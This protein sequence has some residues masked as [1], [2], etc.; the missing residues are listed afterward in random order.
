MG[1]RTSRDSAENLVP[2]GV[3]SPDRPAGNESL[4]RP[5]KQIILSYLLIYV[6]TFQFRLQQD[7]KHALNIKITY[8]SDYFL[9]T[10]PIFFTVSMISK[11]SQCS[12]C[13]YGYANAPEALRSA[14]FLWRNIIV[15]LAEYGD[16]L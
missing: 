4:Y 14:D 6:D 9:L 12:Y 16:H 3:R 13:C 1:S 11:I 7:R 8:I 15:S 5:T 10:S 2:T